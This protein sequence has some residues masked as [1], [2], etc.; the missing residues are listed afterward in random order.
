MFG[1]PSPEVI[2]AIAAEKKRGDAQK[3]REQLERE[4][5]QREAKGKK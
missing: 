4:K 3:S 5:K 2:E 1:E